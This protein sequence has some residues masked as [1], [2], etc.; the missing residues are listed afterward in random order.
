MAAQ[1]EGRSGAADRPETRLRWTCGHD[2]TPVRADCGFV[3]DREVELK[4]PESCPCVRIPE[5]HN[6]IAASR[7]ER[8]PVRAERDR[9]HLVCVPLEQMNDATVFPDASDPVCARRRHSRTGRVERH[10]EHRRRV[11]QR[12]DQ[13]AVCDVPNPHRFCP[14]LP[15]QRS[16]REGRPPSEA[17]RGRGLAADRLRA[18]RAERDRPSPRSQPRGPCRCRRRRRSALRARRSGTTTPLRQSFANPSSP[19]AQQRLAAGVERDAR[20]RSAMFADETKLGV[21][22]PGP[23]DARFRPRSQ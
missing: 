17:H 20:H 11:L 5:A 6:V 10:V 12:S 22:F 23:R 16:L 7:D 15:S 4:S 2:P 3:D 9:G 21:G 13:L 1:E 19:G 8:P 18:A 14:A